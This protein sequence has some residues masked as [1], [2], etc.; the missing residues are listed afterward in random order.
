[1]EQN[2]N[3]KGTVL[4]NNPLFFSKSLNVSE[5]HQ[6]AHPNSS[7]VSSLDRKK[8]RLYLERDTQKR[9]YAGLIPTRSCDCYRSLHNEPATQACLAILSSC[10]FSDPQ[11]GRFPFI[12]IG[13][14]LTDISLARSFNDNFCLQLQW[15]FIEKWA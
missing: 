3:S 9:V 11:E 13:V 4:I 5:S 10:Q 14:M 15:V 8:T 1:M 2:K 12:N 7:F 6:V